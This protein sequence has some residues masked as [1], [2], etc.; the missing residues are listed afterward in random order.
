MIEIEN[1]WF[2]DFVANNKGVR[3]DPFGRALR[4]D[5]SVV[6]GLWVVGEAAGGIH[7]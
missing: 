6:E 7:G 4:K 2:N 1:D 5:N 3:I